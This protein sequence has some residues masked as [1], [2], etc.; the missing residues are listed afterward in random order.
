MEREKE[1]GIEKAGHKAYR[2]FFA[3][4][5]IHRLLH[6]RLEGVPESLRCSQRL[7]Q[8]SVALLVAT[9][10]YFLFCCSVLLCFK[11]VSFKS[12]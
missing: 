3:Y 6:L 11:A 1:Q 5:E 12:L 4:A 7:V 2:A 9:V 10:F 8:R